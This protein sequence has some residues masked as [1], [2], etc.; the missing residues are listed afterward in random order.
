MKG[1]WRILCAV[2]LCCW[3]CAIPVKAVGDGNVD[4]G[5]GSMGQGSSQNVWSPGND[6]V[7]VT[8]VRAEGR[9]PVTRP[10]DLTNK[11]P[12][13]DYSF[14]KV[15]KLSYSGGTALSVDTGTY[16]YV[17][18][19]QALPKIISSQSNGAANIEAI[20]N[21]FTDEQVI[22]SIA[23]LTGMD[24]EVLV[25]GGYK[26]LL[27]PVGYYRFQG[28]MIATT[29]TEAALYDEKL[30][31]GL[32]KRMVSFTHK[33]LPLSMFLETGDLGYPAWGKSTDQTVSDEEIK[34]SLGLG[35]VRFQDILPEGPEVASY[36]YEYRTNTEVITSVRIKGGQSDPEHPVTVTF[37]IGGRDYRVE[38]VYYPEGEEQLAWVR[39]TTPK[40]EQ[41]MEIPVTVEG[42]GTAE[43][44]IITARITELGKDPPPD[45]NA[46]DRNDSFQA[47]QIPYRSEATTTG[48][49][50]WKPW[51]KAEW[52]WHETPEAEEEGYW[53]D[54]GWWEFLLE[55]H[56]ASL[57]A[58][59]ELWGMKNPRLQ[60]GK[61]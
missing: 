61:R 19:A 49:S 53:V 43:K 31:G 52:V 50:V 12:K 35:I 15:C 16:E 26:L 13:I 33:N 51:W 29:A 42:G 39:W 55:R 21:Y 14:G 7:R 40:E 3:L 45:P 6:G 24:F 20:K 56:S 30:S 60:M 46:D 44:G 10:V 37:Q 57:S 36:D 38:N 54:E 18:P 41:V 23:G 58:S 32:R 9:E 28:S 48:W 47:V 59:M 25:S 11:K 4:G 8:V 22:R 27:E 34:S 2:F 17:N 1:K 5:G